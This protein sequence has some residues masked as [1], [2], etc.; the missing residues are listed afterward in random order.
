MTAAL[1]LDSACAAIGDPTRRRILDY[2]RGGERSAGDL[3]EQFPISRPAVSRHLRV[4]REAALVAERREGK[5]RIYR[6]EPAPL[7]VLD[8][9]LASYR[10]FWA[11]RLTD[12]KQLVE[13]RASESRASESPKRET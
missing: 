11:A 7:A 4:L 10:T 1:R 6:L 5:H 12:L 2:L 8:E 9:W 3:A 13:F